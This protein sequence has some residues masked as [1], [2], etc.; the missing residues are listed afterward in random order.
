MRDRKLNIIWVS[1]ADIGGGAEKNAFDIFRGSRLRG[2]MTR[3]IV[4]Y[5]RGDD[6]D[7]LNIPHYQACTGWSR[8]WW[9]VYAHLQSL[10]ESIRGKARVAHLIYRLAEPKSLFDSYQGIENFHYPGIWHLLKLIPEFPDI[11]H[12]HNLHGEYFD[13]RVL[14]WLSQQVPVLLTLHDAWLLSGHCAYSFE[15]ERWQ[16]GCGSCPDL[17]IPPAVARDATAYNW[18]H[19]RDIFAQGRF[20]I[21]TPSHWLMQ[22]VQ[23]SILAPSVQQ[24]QVIP[25]GV[26]LT[27]FHPADQQQARK[28]L[29]IAPEVKMLLFAANGIRRTIWKDFQTMRAAVTRVAELLS[30][31]CLLFVALGEDAPPE[32][33]G[34]AKVQFVPFQKDPN[35]MACYYQA[36]D[37]YLHAARAEVWGLT[38]TEALACGIPVVA[39]AVGG[40]PEQIKSLLPV[41][42]LKSYPSSEATG[43]L[44]PPGGALEMA[45]AIEQLLNDEP[46]CRQLGT[47][48]TEDAHSRFGLDRQVDAYLNWYDEIVGN[49][50]KVQIS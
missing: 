9:R 34:Q 23:H 26:D 36:A 30:D 1:T 5:K 49:Q 8:F 24:A 47:N 50:D 31:Q 29:G 27:I 20:Y 28:K 46:L 48:A 45:R 41:N 37:I 4:G 35:V 7:V 21:S 12:C 18:Q 15:C 16:I 3:L 13:L 11:V 39:T 17:T 33:M 2:Y 38:I 44:V 10:D 25:N 42:N 14:P 22:K 6:P 40:I 43:I 32:Q 19:K